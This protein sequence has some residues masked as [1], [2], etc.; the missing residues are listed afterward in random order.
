[1]GQVRCMKCAWRF[2]WVTLFCRR[3]WHSADLLATVQTSETFHRS[4]H[5]NISGWA[6]FQVYTT[7]GCSR[8]DMWWK[9]CGKTSWEHCIW[10]F[11]LGRRPGTQEYCVPMS[12]W[13]KVQNNRSYSSQCN[14]ENDKTLCVG[15][16]QQLHSWQL[17]YMCWEGKLYTC[18]LERA[19][20]GTRK[21]VVS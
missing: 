3:F 10:L 4:Y 11:E 18:V 2:S 13:R 16:V 21:H 17:Y 12:G 5:R 7:R 9:H 20:W 6:W 15:Q 14:G 19:V 8:Q 1:M